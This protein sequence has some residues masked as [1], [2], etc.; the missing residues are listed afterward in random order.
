MLWLGL[1]CCAPTVGAHA[2]EAP[3]EALDA[4][5]GTDDD[6]YLEDDNTIVVSAGRIKGSVSSGNIRPEVELSAADIQSFGVSSIAELL[7]ELAPQ[8]RSAAGTSSPVVLLNGRRIANFLEIRNIPSEAIRAIEIL[9]EQAA[10]RFGYRADQ[11]VMNIILRERFRTITAELK[12]GM[13]TAGGS[14]QQEAEISLLRLSPNG[15]FNLSVEVERSSA[16]YEDERDLI[17]R[18]SRRPYAIGGNIMAAD[19]GA[20]IDPALS[21]LAGRPVT[22]AG[23]PAS[24][25]AGTATLAD[26]AAGAGIAGVSDT[27][28]WRTLLPETNSFDLNAVY[29]TTL[30]D[31][32]SATFNGRV[33]VSNSKS[34]QGLAEGS[35]LVPAVSPYSPLASDVTL[36]R[37]FDEF[38][39]L[40]QKQDTTSTHLGFTLGGDISRWTWSVTG[41]YDRTLNNTHTRTGA[42]LG[43]VEAAIL[44]GE[45]NPFAPL[46]AEYGALQLFDRA[47]SLTNDADVQFVASGTLAE[48]PA[49]PLS[50]STRVGGKA[51]GIDSWSRRDGVFAASDL[52][53]Q[54]IS[55]QGSI[56]VPL[57]SRRED[58][59]PF[60]GE[61]SVNFNLAYNH[62]SDF[63][64]LRQIGYGTTW[65]PWNPVSL[66]FSMAHEEGVPGIDQLGAAITTITGVR[67]FDYVNGETVD[68]S[69][70]SGGNPNLLADDQRVLKLGITVRPLS[71][72]TLTANYQNSRTDR[73]IASFP[74]ATAALEAAFPDRFTRDA[75]GNLLAIDA[76]PVN[77]ARRDTESLR[78]GFN[79]S[80]RI[81]QSQTPA[82]R[83]GEGAGPTGLPGG[84]G[85]DAGPQ[86]PGAAPGARPGGPRFGP[87]RGPRG[88]RLQFAAYHSWYLTDKILMQE[89]GSTLDLLGGDAIGSGGGQ[90][91]HQVEVQ[92]GITHNGLG[93]RLSGEWQAGTKVQG[94]TAGAPQELRFSDLTTLNLRLFAN[95]GAQ[96]SLV[97]RW[98]L[99]RGTR[100]SL[101]VN[102]LFNQRMTVLDAA[103]QTP[104][105]YQPAYL[106]PTGRSVRLSIRKLFSS[107]PPRRD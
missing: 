100:I 86:G 76:R 8:T 32:V 9:P 99:L 26:F 12:A 70:I 3:R 10:L 79:F 19:P 37:Y 46:D 69:R 36:Y 44:S 14:S 66:N 47:R 7:E 45:I 35:L 48:L 11:K 72:L 56:D 102:N 93:L 5:G 42:D 57:A 33:T 54:S 98:P 50:V 58:V 4:A 31:T 24:A 80:K 85:P 107:P 96:R 106:D 74:S 105:S 49:G 95:L 16:L 67:V 15:R 1:A 83:P 87:G 82:G 51:T 28:P 34:G 104:I 38:A 88:T 27:R 29:A 2:Q 103:G 90:P 21:A 65:T 17:G 89:G 94:G 73:P 52:S 81:A 84:R 62:Y 55:G 91:R 25:A 71:D 43:N 18:A 30:F 68:I 77:F 20:E 40:T 92:T 39:P 97:E 13:P 22:V 63:G 64:T 61:L 41:N 60:L 23:V 59:L 78:W 75:D 101:S 53:R 6:L